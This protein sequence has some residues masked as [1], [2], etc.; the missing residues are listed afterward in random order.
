MDPNFY[1]FLLGVD[2]AKLFAEND[3]VLDAE[4]ELLAKLYTPSSK[5]ADYVVIPVEPFIDIIRTT[6]DK[7]KHLSELLDFLN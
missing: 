6:K 5:S 1:K 7:K 4:I 2:K 3:N